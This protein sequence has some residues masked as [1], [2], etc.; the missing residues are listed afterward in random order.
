MK[1]DFCVNTILKQDYRA[2]PGR[3]KKVRPYE[4]TGSEHRPLNHMMFSFFNASTSAA[5]MPR[6]S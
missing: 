1:N 5:D 6:I 3:C 2:V 4:H